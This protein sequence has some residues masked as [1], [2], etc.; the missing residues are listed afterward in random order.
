MRVDFDLDRSLA[1]LLVYWI[2]TSAEESATVMC[3]PRRAFPRF[4]LLYPRSVFLFA[5][6]DGPQTNAQRDFTF[7]LSVHCVD[8][9]LGQ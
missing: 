8:S 6:A 9:N 5:L 4:R 3:G 1:C 2:S 7:S